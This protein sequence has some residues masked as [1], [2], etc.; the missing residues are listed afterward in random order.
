MQS[1]T[2]RTV[3]FDSPTMLTRSQAQQR[4]AELAYQQ[5]MEQQQLEQ[6]AE[7][8]RGVG[9]TIRDTALGLGAGILGP[10]GED[11]IGG[12]LTLLGA[13]DLGQAARETF[14]GDAEKLRE[15]QTPQLQARQ[16]LAQQRMAEVEG[17][18]F[19]PEAT[20]AVSEYL[21]NPSL[22]FQL[23]T[24]QLPQLIPI[25]RAGRLTR[26]VA[27]RTLK[28]ATEQTLNRAGLGGAASTA[29]ALQGS[30][31]GMETYDRVYEQ[32]IEPCS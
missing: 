26:S 16:Q 28:D 29:G 13:E 9:G 11:L 21:S 17:E 8:S 14:G 22:L 6:T 3:E 27:S 2:G 5:D 18:G 19:I 7:E 4:A 25:A 30:S 24:E 23:G 15:M 12:G 1:S 20:T 31:V 32:G 10:I